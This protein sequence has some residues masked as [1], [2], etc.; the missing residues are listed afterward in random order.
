MNAILGF[1]QILDERIES[2][3]KLRRYTKIIKTS[4]N[5]LLALINDILDLSKI[6]ANQLNVYKKEV[7]AS[8]IL[9]KI[10]EM[11]K[12]YALE[13]KKSNLKLILDIPQK[14]TIHTDEFR[15]E[16][17]LMNLVSNAIKFTDTGYIKIG[18]TLKPKDIEFYIKDTG[19]GLNPEEQKQVFNRFTQIHDENKLTTGTGL[20]LALCNSLSKLLKGELKVFSEKNVGS[21]FS[22]FLP[23]KPNPLL[24]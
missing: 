4:G 20:G 12:A 9:R 3:D 14:I 17:I 1:A 5:Y 23:L 22:L 13:K 7:E 6:E 8:A 16:Q 15:L 18:Y 11:A 24:K 2:N 10:H 21:T 19:I